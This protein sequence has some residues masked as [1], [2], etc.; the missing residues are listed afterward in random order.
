[1]SPDHVEELGKLVDAPVAKQTTDAGHPR[2]VA[3]LEQRPVG[4]VAVGEHREPPVRIRH[5]RAE[6]VHLEVPAPHPDARL[7]EEHGTLRELHGD[8]DHEEQGGEQHQQEGRDDDVEDPL[9]R[10]LRAREAHRL[11]RDRQRVLHLREV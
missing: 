10:G 7:M 3:D 6:L 9:G 2:V 5:H 4:F 11:Q 8:R 1:M